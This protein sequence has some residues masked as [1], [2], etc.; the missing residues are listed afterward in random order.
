MGDFDYNFINFLQN[1]G[2][3]YYHNI[4]EEFL[5]S[6]K[7]NNI[8]L[9][10]GISGLGKTKFAESFIKYYNK[11]SGE[12][13]TIKSSSKIG[14]SV[15]NKGFVIPRKD[16]YGVIPKLSYE[17]ECQL[18]VDDIIVNGRFN[19]VP[20]FFYK[21][22]ENGDFISY[23]EKMKEN[24]ETRFYYEF[25]IEKSSG[26]YRLFNAD[27]I[28]DLD[29]IN[30]LIDKAKKD[31]STKYFII[32]NN[33]NDENINK[34]FYNQYE[35]PSNLFIFY[36]GEIYDLSDYVDKLS[37]INFEAIAPIDYLQNNLFN[38][39]FKDFDYL[40]SI[41]NESY[42]L[43]D[44]KTILQGIYISDNKNLYHLLIDELNKIYYILFEENIFLTNKITEDI[45]KYMIISWKYEGCPD[46]FD[47]WN[48]YFDF[49]I[50]QK[51]LPL[52]GKNDS[53]DLIEKFLKYSNN[54][55]NFVRSYTLCNKLL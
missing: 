53:I 43:N 41:E 42:D 33:V 9:L 15:K 7:I 46:Q 8:I 19:L 17:D 24:N 31:S 10:N 48:K 50:T 51:I 39:N 23:L 18:I 32:F 6:I 1:Y 22:E 26:L 35:I 3:Y 27:K 28:K 49:Q 54:D 52:L 44:I 13:E 16:L 34:I 4:I 37:V 30:K 40:E 45:L 2:L 38:V 11:K 36:V 25:L 12:F 20:R 14:K 47:N 21:A 5:L 29:L 55:Y